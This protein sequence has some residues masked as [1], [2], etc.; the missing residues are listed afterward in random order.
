MAIVLVDFRFVTE[1]E[2]KSI[3]SEIICETA[4]PMTTCESSSSS[5]SS[6]S[7]LSDEYSNDESEDKDVISHIKI[8]SDYK[9]LSTKKGK[10]SHQSDSSIKSPTQTNQV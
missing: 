4:I 2:N 7:T 3:S 9:V 6:S 5:S 8:N 10:K 1:D